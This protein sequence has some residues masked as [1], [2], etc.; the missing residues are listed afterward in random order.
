M[1]CVL[2]IWTTA[3]HG[4]IDTNQA[5]LWAVRYTLTQMYECGEQVISSVQARV[6]GEQEDD[7]DLVGEHQRRFCRMEAV[8]RKC[9]GHGRPEV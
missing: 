2:P 4:S 7:N 5:L 1:R 8:P 3:L 9:C 6:N